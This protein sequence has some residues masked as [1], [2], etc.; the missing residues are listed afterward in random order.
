M[1]LDVY[2]ECDKTEPERWAIFI[3][4]DGQTKEIS[5]EEWNKRFP[6]RRPSLAHVG[7]TGEVYSGNITHNL[8]T[9]AEACGLYNALWRPDETGISKADQLIPILADGLRK[10]LAN[11]EKYKA[12]NPANGWGNYDNLV[13]FVDEYLGACKENPTANVHVSR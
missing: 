13:K 7:G 1:S 11:P 3:R 10:L 6:G 9:M 2:L 5:L 8:R 12:H 4:E